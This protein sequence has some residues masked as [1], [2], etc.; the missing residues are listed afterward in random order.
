MTKVMTS[1]AC[2]QLHERGIIDLDDPDVI[3]KYAPELAKQPILKGYTSDGPEGKP[4][5]EKRTR[6]MTLKHLLSHSAGIGYGALIPLLG[7]WERENNLPSWNAKHAVVEAYCVPLLDEP[8]TTF[9]YGYGIDWAGIIVWRVT[10]QTLEEYFSEN[11]WKPC[12]VES[13]TFYPRDDVRNRL[14]QLCGRDQDGKLIHIDGFR[15]VPRLRPEDIGVLS[16][17]G[18]TIGP[19][20]EYLVFLQ[21]LLQCKDREGGILSPAG[22]KL[23]FTNAL[24]P[25]DEKPE[26]YAALGAFLGSFGHKDPGMISG[27]TVS[28]SVGLCLIE[29][30]SDFSRK[31]GTG[32]WGGAAKTEYWIDPEKGIIVSLDLGFCLTHRR[33][34][35]G[36][37][38]WTSRTPCGLRSISSIRR[39]CTPLSSRTHCPCHYEGT[40]SVEEVI[41]GM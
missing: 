27:D 34:S 13:I 5:Y 21:H 3:E 30:D 8:G 40:M 19:L 26:V 17:G 24:P 23:L 29:A 41:K 22:F 9:M 4:I 15:P 37:T 14:M 12:G 16:G 20:K 1:I 32:W 36:R 10:G 7:R 39:S 38:F 18:H 11:I 31:A 33:A 28:H 6:P 35:S 25:R 2:V